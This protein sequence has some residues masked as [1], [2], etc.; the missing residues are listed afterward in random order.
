MTILSLLHRN[1]FYYWRTN[2]A[3]VA[4]VA[5]AV[6][7]FA[8][9][10]LVGDSVRESL[11][12][13]A[14]SR[15]GRTDL[16]VTGTS[17]FREGLVKELAA[18]MGDRSSLEAVAP[19][20]A[21]TGMALE[22]QSQAR[23]GGVAVYGV[24]QRFWEFHGVEVAPPQGAEVLISRGL[25]VELG[26]EQGDP[27]VVRVEKPSPI[28][29]ESLFGRKDDA[30]RSMRVTVRAVLAPEQM[31][32]FSLQPSQG[33]V[34]AVFLPLERV[35]R[36][37][38]QDGLVNAL[39]LSARPGAVEAGRAVREA[40]RLV[41]ER[42]ALPD[43]GLRLR[44]IEPIGLVPGSLAVESASGVLS[45]PVAAQVRTVARQ[46]GWETAAFLTYLA[47]TIR[48]GEREVPYSLVTALEVP[49]EGVG[50]E[51]L[52]IP[53]PL[54][55]LLGG[56]RREVEQ[57][58]L[59][60]L[61]LNEWTARDLGAQV[62]DPI[63]LDYYLWRQ[64]GT[65]GTAATTFRLAGITPLEGLAADRNLAPEYPGI[66]GSESLS[67]WDPPFPLDLS[68]V[69]KVDE[70]YWEDY[71]TTPKAYL[72][73]ADGQTLWT[74]RYGRLT[75]LR[76]TPP[77]G[78]S[79]ASLA[80]RQEELETTLRRALD[81]L[82]L[83]IAVQS[84]RM[85]NLAA[86]RGATDFGAY[87]SYFSFFLMVSALLLVALFFR[88]GLEQRAR[89][90]GL[91]WAL[92]YSHREVRG[93]LLREGGGLA[94]LGS[95]VG[96]AGA[97]LYAAL[98]MYGLRTW[99]V[100]AVGT[101]LL[102]L[103][104]SA[105][106]LLIGG[107][108]GVA[109]AVVVIAV[110]LRSLGRR[111]PRRLLAGTF[112]VQSTSP[113]REG[114]APLHHR[115]WVLATLILVVGGLLL[116]VIWGGL[117][118]AAGF[119]G[120]GTLLL[121]ILLI[122]CS[123]WLYHQA[124]TTPASRF[125]GHGIWPMVSLG[126]RNAT[127][128]PQRSLLCIALIAAATFLLVS[129]EAFRRG[130]PSAPEDRQSGTGGFGLIAE[131]LLPIVPHPDLPEGRAE[132]DLE[133]PVLEGSRVTRFRLRS[134]EDTSCLNLY[135]PRNPR[136]LGVPTS[137]IEQGRFSFRA[138]MAETEVERANPW[139]LLRRP[140]VA[141]LDGDSP[142][143]PVIADANSLAYVLHRQ[144]GEDFELM[145]GDGRPVRLRI[146]ASL[147]DSLFQGELLMAE[148]AFLRLFPA[149]VGYRWFAVDLPSAQQAAVAAFLEERLDDYGFDAVGAS[150][151]L[152]RFHEVE[153]TYLSTFQ[154]LGGLGLLLGTL[155]LA[156][157]LLR[158][159]LER[160]SELA[161]L[162]AIGYRQSHLFVQVVAENLLLL[163]CGLL[164]GCLSAAVAIG[165]ALLQRGGPGGQL[166]GGSLALL[167][168]AV[169]VTGMLASL[170]ALRAVARTPLL[171]ALR[172]E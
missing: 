46:L 32:E 1:L 122:G 2:L 12:G 17:F 18:E 23:A 83:G 29:L 61:V 119:F 9:A 39:L 6:A 123:R 71:R 82:A 13:L 116:W 159:V 94:L 42:F 167:L 155:G 40:E 140:I 79:G 121:L 147:A 129:V 156:I 27:L 43:L 67:D 100:G 35:Q 160:R 47:N 171:T 26:L 10:L 66:T 58:S 151:K 165:P 127:L 170:L 77:T 37:L 65:L 44:P 172:G 128:S 162:R 164:M 109:M 69:R 74:T 68:R 141:T 99:W 132:L 90:V 88:L 130:A 103:S 124:G 20:I 152:A 78:E 131:S 60:L 19:L 91:Y 115:N 142:I 53:R 114:R 108:A 97:L 4:G 104:V 120:V 81:P 50:A 158:N 85:E 28:P 34:R 143:V 92:G 41:R 75:S 157:V 166:W 125:R 146:V 52:G 112:A 86:S 54:L 153:N 139:E 117:D 98:M 144:V 64:E 89:E 55:P 110:T 133:S 73:L 126:F 102:Q 49:Q 3:V 95:L 161:L 33:M 56:G 16:L 38:D 145:A 57:D 101:S 148:E 137:F 169:L 138:T 106:S 84:V 168:L 8:G 87:F 31:G 24:D 63:T 11:R 36:N 149:E 59:P 93:L 21:M 135:Q 72:S 107:G 105:G 136:I 76:L 163:G 134:G 15:L 14:L 154:T 111:S 45:E 118:P 48:R 22:D 30:G 150:E 70:A 5:T 113:F 51:A 80:T 62:G 96:M 25:A 7:V